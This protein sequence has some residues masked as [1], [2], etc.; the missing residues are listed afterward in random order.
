MKWFKRAIAPI[1]AVAV[2]LGYLI[3]YGLGTIL[4]VGYMLPWWWL[5]I[6]IATLLSLLCGIVYALCQRIGEIK[7]E[8]ESDV[9][10]KY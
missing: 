10:R 5:A 2:I 3:W 8:D 6:L 7:R 4:Y 1:V 9:T